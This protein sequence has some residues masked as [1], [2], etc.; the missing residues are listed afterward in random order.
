MLRYEGG[1]WIVVSCCL[2]DRPSDYLQMR[3]GRR[4]PWMGWGIVHKLGGHF[5]L[6][7]GL[8]EEGEEGQEEFEE[9]EKILLSPIEDPL[10]DA[11][12]DDLTLGSTGQSLM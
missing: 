7:G 12:E 1:T 4:R 5:W 11:S 3:A 9:K 2:S 6:A 10:Y 8:V